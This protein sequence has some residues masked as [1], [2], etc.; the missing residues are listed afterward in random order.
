MQSNIHKKAYYLSGA[1]HP[2][3]NP[4]FAGTE[5]AETYMDTG[6]ISLDM[7]TQVWSNYSTTGM[8]NWGTIGDG[9]TGIIETAGDEGLIVA[10]G[11]YTYPLGEAMSILAGRQRDWSRRVSHFLHSLNVQ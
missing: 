10:F 4:T 9:Y 11:G 6:L 1:L 8:N 3:G 7:T 5:G 2:N